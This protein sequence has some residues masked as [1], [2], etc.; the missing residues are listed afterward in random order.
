MSALTISP[1]LAAVIPDDPETMVRVLEGEGPGTPRRGNKSLFAKSECTYYCRTAK[2]A[3]AVIDAL[4]DSD[5]RLR[6]RPEELMLW[7]W[8]HTWFRPERGSETGAGWVVLGVV[9]YDPEFYTERRGAY[10]SRMHTLIYDRLDLTVDDVEV[11][12]YLV[13]PESQAA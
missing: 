7:D 9:W 1:A 6:S 3:A 13:D 10:L 4:R 2:I 8:Q 5:E 11:T 12:H